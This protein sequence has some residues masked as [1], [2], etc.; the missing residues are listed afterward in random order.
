ME[1][2]YIKVRFL[3][4]LFVAVFLT[5]CGSY[6]QVFETETTNASVTE[7]KYIFENDSIKVEYDFWADQGIMQ[8]TI[9]NKLNKPIYIDWKKSSYVNDGVKL[10][11]WEDSEVIKS[12]GSMSTIGYLGRYTLKNF[13]FYTSTTESS[14]VVTKSERI[15]FIPPKSTFKK[16]SFKLLPIKKLPIRNYDWEELPHIKDNGKT[17]KTMVVNYNKGNSPLT[18][19][20]FFTFSTTESFEK[21]VYV[22]N[23]FY[24]SK[25]LKVDFHQFK[26]LKHE[27]GKPVRGENGR[28][29]KHSPFEKPKSFYLNVQP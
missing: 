18:F 26:N 22:D 5:S 16:S 19:R 24:V 4:L 1:Q 21:E 3:L 13:S 6:V 10:N 11:Y 2:V 12:V 20:N 8:F 29:F 7:N 17:I 27:N 23:E 25:L 14:S 9:F 15:T 28:F